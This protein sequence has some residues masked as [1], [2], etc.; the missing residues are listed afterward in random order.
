LI[1]VISMADSKSSK[2]YLVYDGVLVSPDVP[3]LHSTNRAFRYGDGLF[4]TI[5]FH[6]G[7]PL[8]WRF[9]YQRLLKGM[10]V[11]KMASGSFPSRQKI[12]DSITDLVVKNR[13]FADARVRLTVFR[14][15][16]G[17]YT[18]DKMQVS[19]LIEAT[20]LHQ[21]GYSFPEK[22]LKID[23]YKDFP[24]LFSPISPFKTVG[25]LP[26]VMAGI[27]CAENNLDDCLLVNGQGKLIESFNS[28]LFWV[29]DNVVYTPLISSGC[30]DGIFRQRVMDAV[31]QLGIRLV[32]STGASE[33]ELRDADEVFLTNSISGLRWVAAFRE[34]RYF[35]KVSKMIFRTIQ[36]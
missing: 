3:L 7:E 13:I 14:K 25:S 19:W 8:H 26:Y 9:H 34:H 35:T 1:L 33:I 27:F 28:S 21:T 29:K 22:G 17:L 4:E 30:I 16:E 36:S 20:N 23:I 2:Q 10:A 6:K 31:R 5:R 24:K 11:L 12:Q 32:E 18:P 15:G